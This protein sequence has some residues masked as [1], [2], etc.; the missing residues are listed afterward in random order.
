MKKSHLFHVKFF[1]KKKKDYLSQLWMSNS[2]KPVTNISGI[3]IN[4]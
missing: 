2:K 1:W 3:F 4:I